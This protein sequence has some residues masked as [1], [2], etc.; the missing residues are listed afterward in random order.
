MDE[1]YPND[2]EKAARRK[3]V[4]ERMYEI[5]GLEEEYKDGVIGKFQD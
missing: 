1:L 5:A 3:K 2:P 4:M